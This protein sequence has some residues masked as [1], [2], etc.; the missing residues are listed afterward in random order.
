MELDSIKRM[1]SGKLSTDTCKLLTDLVADLPD[2]GVALD[3]YCGEGLSTVVLAHSMDY[4]GK[5]QATVIAVD[6]HVTNPI[7][8]TPH[9]DGSVM[10]HLKNLRSQRVLHRVT[11]IVASVSLVARLPNKRSVNLVVVQVPANSA[12]MMDSLLPEV[13]LGQEVIRNGGKIVVCCPNPA[14]QRDF[15]ESVGRCFL[16]K[17]FKLVIDQPDVKVYECEVKKNGSRADRT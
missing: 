2:A 1:V 10:K 11:P 15:G 12:T 6:T 9:E 16:S 3:L 5:S 7:S 13:Q 8:D 4:Y 14:L 17:D